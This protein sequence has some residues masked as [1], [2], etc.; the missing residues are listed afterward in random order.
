MTAA[1]GTDADVY[2]ATDSTVA[3]FADWAYTYDSFGRIATQTVSGYG[4]S[5]TTGQGTFTFTYT[6]SSNVDGANSWRTKTVETDP[7][8]NTI[9]VYTNSFGQVMLSVYDAGT[10][11]QEATYYQYNDA[12]ECILMANPS[13]VSG[14]DDTY[15]NLNPDLSADSGLITDYTYYSSTTATTSTAGGVAGYQ[16]EIDLQDGSD[17]TPIPQ[18]TWTYIANTAGSVTIF[19][20]ATNTVY[21]NTDGT[22]G[23]T[24]SYSYTYFSGTNQVESV[25][26][27]L[28][29]VTT[30]QNGSG[31][32]TTTVSVSNIQGQVVWTKDQAGVI[33]Y[34]AYDPAT[35]AVVEQI[36][37][38]DTS[39]TSDY[40]GTAP[41]TTSS[42][43]GLNQVT[44]YQVDALGRTVE[45]TDPDG[46]VTWTVYNDPD[47]EVLTYTGWNSTTHTAT[48]PTQVYR[49]DWA[50]G[51][52]ETLTMTAAPS[53]A[54]TSGNYYPT[55]TETIGGVVSLTRDILNDAGQVTEE[56]DYFD[57]SGITY[58]QS[59]VQLGTSGTNYYATLYGYDANGLLD[60]TET[61]TGTIYRTVYDGQ[62]RQVSTWVGTDD[63]P[64]SGTWSPANLTGTNMVETEADVYD[65]GGVGD[66]NLT[67][68]TL[69]TG[70]SGG[71]DPD[72]VSQY[73]Y[74][75]RDREI[76]EKDGV[77]STET[78]GTNRPITI[79]TYDNLNEITQTQT[80][81]GDGIPLT[82]AVVALLTSAPTDPV[83]YVAGDAS[84]GGSAGVEA[85]GSDSSGDIFVAGG[86]SGT[87]T[88]GSGSGTVTLNSSSGN[89]FVAEYT[90]AGALAW[91]D[92]VSASFTGLAVD[93]SG[94]IV[95]VGY[96]SGTTSFGGTTL[97]ASGLSDGFVWKLTGGGSSD[98]A[99]KADGT[100]AFTHASGVA[101]D[102][103]GNVFVSGYA[104][105]PSTASVSFG[106]ATL[107][108]AAGTAQVFV[109]K[110]DDSGSTDWA[111]ETTGAGKAYAGGNIA[112][113]AAGDV[114]VGG[115]YSYSS[116]SI[117]GTTLDA[118]SSSYW[119]GFVWKLDGSGSTDWVAQAAGEYVDIESIGVATDSAGDVY[120]YGTFETGYGGSAAFGT[121]E[122]TVI[123]YSTEGFVW[124][125]NS[126]GSTDWAVQ[127]A[128]GFEE[129]YASI[130]G[131]AI[132]GSGNVYVTGTA[133]ASLTTVGVDDPRPPISNNPF[134][135][136]LASSGSTDSVIWSTGSESTGSLGTSGPVVDIAGDVI[137]TGNF[138]GTTNFGGDSLASD[139]SYGSGFVWRAVD[140]QTF[141]TD[142]SYDNLGELYQTQT[143]SVDPNTGEIGNSLTS[144]S[145]FDSRGNVIEQTQPDGPVTKYT[146]NGLDEL[147]AAY[148]TDGGSG[149]TYSDASSVSSDVVL[150]QTEYKYDNDGNVIETITS[151]RLSTDSATT[152]SA[153]SDGTVTGVGANIS[154]AGYYYDA[155]S[156]LTAEVDVGNN[157]GS[158]WTMPSSCASRSSTALV[159]TYGYD[160]PATS[161][162]SPTP[163]ALSLS[164]T[165]MHWAEQ[166]KQSK[167]TAA[168]TTR[169]NIRSTRPA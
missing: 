91:I 125:L 137:A 67:Q 102:S 155:A 9:T 31:D 112:V 85:I 149:T 47:H 148:T 1:G 103:S 120:A 19:Q 16:E 78:D 4:S 115:F 22:G 117:G 70:V 168:S 132:D 64:T 5:A 134:V 157:G 23:E 42:G 80:F 111:V 72:Q 44:T 160:T 89:G 20:V 40:S 50:N 131:V 6:T 116:V 56:D 26:T 74:D 142:Y 96:F 123:P 130:D 45:Q 57:L 147:T 135:W 21:R 71:G 10:D 144:D 79:N 118:P 110:L 99:V 75:W 54:G 82:A 122:L 81:N 119:S 62:D 165:S 141:Q 150:T 124:K 13:A 153:L 69:F 34:I 41:W 65:N 87:V 86:I 24:T 121:A 84:T 14:Y 18:E 106:S 37:N 105:A 161:T 36:N 49:E 163:T 17:G 94:N 152:T 93:G 46:N 48:G 35:G 7:D 88:F 77:S 8:G 109:W 59:T 95:T 169:P 92:Q 76:A 58:S 166:P 61:A 32:A 28:P 136:K 29:A 25:T 60:R 108:V 43:N 63:T 158:A 143:Y 66:G 138:Y 3:E 145:Y 51:Y 55:G 104:Y 27:T 38:V 83:A 30:D 100:G 129:G 151:D 39:V 146:F 156:R 133:D 2:A 159:T 90:S 107:T 140:R 97:T 12:G 114:Y 164:L 33:G 154:Y 139:S 52:T 127:A 101:V 167:T 113:D 11:Q 126:S 73:L 68:Q 98:W 53:Y 15:A 162:K 128:T